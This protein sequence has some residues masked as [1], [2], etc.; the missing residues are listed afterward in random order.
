MLNFI[1]FYVVW[2]GAN[3]YH[4]SLLRL[5]FL[6]LE[7]GQFKNIDTYKL[8]FCTMN[9][10][11]TNAWFCNFIHWPFRKSWSTE[12]CRS[13]K[14]WHVSLCNI[15]KKITIVSITTDLSRK[16]LSVRKLSSLL[17]WIQI[18][19]KSNFLSKAWIFI[20]GNI[21]CIFEVTNLTSLIFEKIILQ[22]SKSYPGIL[23]NYYT[24][25]LGYSF[26]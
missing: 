7:Y 12:L 4:L 21:Y 25:S 23:V 26:E 9:G 2:F 20:T 11:F 10:S 18:S 14:Y 24:L 8:L 22:T 6:Y 3:S 1:L 13:C 16:A 15:K 5:F 19:P 17:R